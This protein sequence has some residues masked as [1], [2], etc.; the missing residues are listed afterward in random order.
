MNPTEL[1]HPNNRQPSKAYLVNELRKA[2]FAWR[3][4]GYQAATPTTKRLLQFWF[5]EDHLLNDEPYQL[6]FCQ[7]EA[8]ETLIYVYEVMKKINFIDMAK[9]FGSGQIYGYDPSNDQYPLYAF[10]MATGS[11]KTYVMA[12]SIL[13]QYFNHKKENKD[14]Y[15]SKFLLIAGEKNII[16]DR[17]TR[18]FKSGKIFRELPIIPTEWMEGFDLEV[19][20]KEDPIHVIPESVLFLTNIQQLQERKNTREEVSIYVNQ[21]MEL[22]EV[23]NVNDIY[24]ENRIKEVLTSCPNIA[25]LKDEAHHIY[26]FEKKWKQIL[27]ELHKS[28]KSQFAQGVNMELD[29]SATPKNENGALFPWIISDFSLK[30]AIEMNIVKRPLK[31]VLKNAKEIASKKSVERYRAWIDAGIKRWREYKKALSPLSKRPVLF[32]QCSENEEA[33][34]V[35]EYVNSLRDLKDKVLLIH[36][37]ST[38]EVT[39]KDLP[40]AREFAKNI[41]DPEKSPYEVIISTMMLNEGWDVRNVNVIVGLR[42]YGSKREVLPEQVI[43]RGLRKMF[44]EEDANVDKSINVLEVIGPAGL[45]DILEE[46][47]KQEGIKFNEFDAGKPLNL[48]TIFVDE[49]KLDKNIEIPILSRRM[50]IR[51]FYLDDAAVDSLP[52]LAIPLENKI[53]ETEYIAVDMLNGRE[54]INRK[55]ELPVPRDPKSVIAYYTDRI[56]K[57]LKI[58]GAFDSF[59][60]LVKKYVSEKLFNEKINFADPRVL[61]NLSSPEVQE[62]L[63]QLFVNAF[64]ELRFTEREPEQSDIIKISATAP[65]PWTKLIFPAD[66]CIFNYVPCDNDFEVDFAKFLDKAEDVKAF[67][68]IVYKIP[69]FVEYRDSKGNLRNYHPDFVAVNDKDKHIIV[70]TKGLIDIDVE[71]KDKRIKIWCEDATNLTKEKWSFVRVN[72]QDFEKYNFQNLSELVDTVKK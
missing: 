1:L 26:S 48:T 53:L 55:W 58:G 63:M 27:I 4:Q 10:K 65:F 20:L 13:W 35:F 69:F 52:A 3:Q 22:Q 7:R 32:F 49:N 33:D 23:Y 29:F 45:T 40:Q 6:W 18:D 19:I 17:L 54:V 36:T 8:I 2:V 28:L 71:H 21:V 50:I 39:K 41:D 31:G 67:A 44:P 61:Y 11:G 24:Q 16:Y 47:E 56:L 46:L 5:Q 25:I 30:E 57:E 38:G 59:Y 42:P 14:D 9:D 43:G 66:R 15:T 68:K 62:K 60:P 72:Q 64:H 34:E 70:E 12:L 37:D 51:E